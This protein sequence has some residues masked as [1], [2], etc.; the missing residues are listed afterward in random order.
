VLGRKGGDNPGQVRSSKTGHNAVTACGISARKGV[1][2]NKDWAQ[3]VSMAYKQWEINLTVTK[4][5]P[6]IGAFEKCGLSPFNRDAF[7]DRDFVRSDLKLGLT[8]DHEDVKKAKAMQVEELLVI[9][10]SLKASASKVVRVNLADHIKRA[11]FDLNMAPITDD[12]T[13]KK[14]MDVEDKKKKE[15]EDKVERAKVRAVRHAEIVAENDAKMARKA[16]K[17][18]QPPAAP[19]AAGAGVAA[20]GAVAAAPVAARKAKSASASVLLAAAGASNPYARA[21]MPPGV[22]FVRRRREYE[23]VE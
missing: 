23:A 20:A 10:D 11:G 8:R 4:K 1:V 12:Y 18:A 17:A 22:G 16:V 19:A 9:I 21:Y 14:L 2:V 7:G 13:V 3:L 5:H 15:E 6:M